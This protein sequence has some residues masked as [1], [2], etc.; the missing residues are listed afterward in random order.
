MSTFTKPVLVVDGMNYFIRHFMAS[1]AVT[2]GGDL[3]GG[4]VGF[5]KGLGSLINTLHPDQVIVVWEQGGPSPRRKHIFSEYKANRATNK[6]LQS[7]YR[8]DGKFIANSD[9]KNKV[10]QLQLLAK[11]LG[12]MPV[13][14]VYVPDTEADDIIA[15][16][17][18][19]K[20]QGSQQTKIVVSNDKDFYQLLEDPT[21]RIYDPARKILIDEAW[22]LEKFSI[23]PRNITLARA[24]VGDTSDNIDGVD[25]VG[26]KTVANRFPDVARTDVDLDLTWIRE[27]ANEA[28]SG[29]GG[30]KKKAPKCYMDIV[31]N[32]STVER[33]WNLMFLDTSC[34][35]STQIDKI[36]Y[37]LENYKTVCNRLEFIKT[38]VS[39]DVTFSMD[40]DS[41]F[42]AA[43]TLVR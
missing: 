39:A 36:N 27:A 22:V 35:A 32:M 7:A 17:V 4:V 43:K 26:L 19:R 28:I 1:E 31:A 15:Y 38:F 24:V 21:I 41:A 29:S 2:V 11:A 14:Q 20:L 9:G 23:S 30:K 18:K 5:I 12:S 37:K 8:N 16:I 10:F 3:V 34:L 40:L 33:N 6:E 13:C 25:G 42:S